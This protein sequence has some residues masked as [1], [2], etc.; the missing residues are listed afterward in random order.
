LK[1]SLCGLALCRM[2]VRFY[3]LNRIRGNTKSRNKIILFCL[4]L[5]CAQRLFLFVVLDCS[6]LESG[7]YPLSLLLQEIVG[8]LH[9]QDNRNDPANGGILHV[10]ASR[11]SYKCKQSTSK[12]AYSRCRLIISWSYILCSVHSLDGCIMEIKQ[13]NKNLKHFLIL[14]RIG[15]KFPK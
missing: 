1:P 9:F 5:E 15:V 10:L 8:T 13:T 12:E 6:T 3:R 2:T 7:V 14:I 4:L 11:R